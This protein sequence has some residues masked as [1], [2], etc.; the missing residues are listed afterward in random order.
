VHVRASETRPLSHTARTCEGH[1]V[2]SALH[3]IDTMS[4]NT[5]L[6]AA[7]LLSGVGLATHSRDASAQVSTRRAGADSTVFALEDTSGLTLTG[8]RATAVTYR[9]RQSVR[10]VEAAGSPGLDPFGGIALIDGIDFH[11]GTIELQ[12]A[13]APAPG[14][15]TSVRGFVGLV[16]RS[17][18]D[19]SRFETF[20]LRAT[21]GR[22][23]DQLRRNHAVQYESSPDYP[24]FRLRK[25]TPGR[26]E[27]FA[28]L[29]PGVWTRMRI[30]VDG[31]R[32]QLFVNDAKQP[33]LVV[34]DLKLGDTGGGIGLWVGPG[35]EAY[36]SHATVIAAPPH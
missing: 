5:V 14:A 15:D 35:T 29:E 25:E 24:W 16:F 22:A 21:N 9:G 8:S 26:Y 30:V 12:V 13:G 1:I 34:N 19:A 2:T 28:D 7:L 17:A 4:R 3:G 23:Q 31:T 33:C 20:Y 18:R 27:S 36:F 10:L 32:A 6:Q 11:N